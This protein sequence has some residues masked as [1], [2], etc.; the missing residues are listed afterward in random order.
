MKCEQLSQAMTQEEKDAILGRTRREYREAKADLG[1]IK[2]R[3]ADTVAELKKFVS[4]FEQDPLSLYVLRRPQ[5]VMQAAMEMQGAHY[6]YTASLADRLTLEGIE[7]HLAEY[8]AIQSAVTDRR[9]S[10][11]EQGD[12]DP[13]GV[14]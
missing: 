1:T 12:G 2:K 8:R 9:V 5:G 4:A 13:G 7:K 10:L 3:H 14:E 11:I 6:L